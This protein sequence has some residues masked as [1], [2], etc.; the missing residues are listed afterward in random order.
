MNIAPLAPAVATVWSFAVWAIAEGAVQAVGVRQPNTPNR[1]VAALTP[2]LVALYGSFFLGWLDWAVLE[3][4]ALGPD[5]KWLRWI[6]MT[7]AI[8]G[9]GLRL[10]T[11]RAMGRHFSGYVQTTEGHQLVTTGLF[12]WVRHPIYLATLLLYVGIPL[13]FT[14]L[15]VLGV[16]L[17]IGLPALWRRIGIEEASLAEWFGDEFT[18]YRQRTKRLIPFVW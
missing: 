15:G 9:F 8:A 3:W 7:L 10:A 6:G 12:A 1:Q 2:L 18:E 17:A 14:S 16:T 11:R 4:T 13:G 5:W